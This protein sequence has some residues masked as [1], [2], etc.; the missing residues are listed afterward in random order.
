MVESRFAARRSTKGQPSVRFS[1][2]W[3]RKPLPL[4]WETTTRT[5]MH[6]RRLT[7]EGLAFWRA[8]S[9]GP[10]LRRFGLDRRKNSSH[11]WPRG[12]RH[13]EKDLLSK[14]PIPLKTKNQFDLALPGLSHPSRRSCP[15]SV[16]FLVAFCDRIGLRCNGDFHLCP[17]LQ[18]HRIA[19]LIGQS[20]FNT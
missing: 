6:S 16:F 11:Y 13:V 12:S 19:I 4:I 1:T 3:I 9:S 17:W 18:S 7:A 10:R 2:R 8:R 20:I 5:R 15:L 14:R